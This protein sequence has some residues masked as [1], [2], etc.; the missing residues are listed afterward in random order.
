MS[1]SE[2]ADTG[3]PCLGGL[4]WFGSAPHVFHLPAG[5]P[6]NVLMEGRG[7]R[8]FFKAQLCLTYEYPIGQSQSHDKP[9]VKGWI[10]LHPGE[11]TQN[12]YMEKGVNTESGKEL[13]PNDAISHSWCPGSLLQEACEA[14]GLMGHQVSLRHWDEQNCYSSSS[15]LFGLWLRSGVVLLSPYTPAPGENYG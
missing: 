15:I 1:G 12:S 10:E 3:W 11:N 13:Q 6:G 9:I 2:L 5:W 4:G 8:G 7:S 14:A